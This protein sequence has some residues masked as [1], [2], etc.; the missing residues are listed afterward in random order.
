[1]PCSACRYCAKAK[2]LFQELKETTA[3]IE[4]DEHAQGAAIQDELATM[5]TG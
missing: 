2:K 5:Y 1:M 4:L 3:V